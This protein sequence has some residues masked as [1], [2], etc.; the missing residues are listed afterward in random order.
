MDELLSGTWEPVRASELRD[1]PFDEK[2]GV[3]GLLLSRLAD[4]AR[5]AYRQDALTDA[6]HGMG[7]SSPAFSLID[8]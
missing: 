7:A 4:T 3:L 1:A 5:A 6:L 2:L 8:A